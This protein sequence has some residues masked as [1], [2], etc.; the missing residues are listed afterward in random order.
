VGKTRGGHGQEIGF[1]GSEDERFWAKVNKASGIFM[2]ADRTECWVWTGAKDEN[3]YGLFGLAGGKV[4][5]AHIRSFTETY[6]PAKLGYE[7]D[8]LCRV[9]AC[10]RPDHMEEVTTKVNVLRSQGLCAENARKS[11][12]P[13]GHP[14]DRINKKGRRC[15][16]ICIKKAGL[17]TYY[18]KHERNKE[19]GRLRMQAR[20]NKLKRTD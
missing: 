16:S 3:G 19:K 11:T 18:R 20:R 4:Q 1:L 14:Y 10:V 2:I 13:N 8:H 9:T 5:R 7:R 6:G 12:C 15:C 17:A